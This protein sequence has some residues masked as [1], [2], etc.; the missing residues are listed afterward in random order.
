MVAS[1]STVHTV[2]RWDGAAGRGYGHNAKSSKAT[3]AL[4][5][6]EGHEGKGT[7]IENGTTLLPGAVMWMSEDLIGAKS[8]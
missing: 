6:K 5:L 7:F 1:A 4:H 3:A 2:R 8:E